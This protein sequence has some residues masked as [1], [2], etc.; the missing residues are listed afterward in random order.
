MSDLNRRQFVAGVA[1][2][3]GTGVMGTATAIAQSPGLGPLS[4]LQAEDFHPLVGQE[5]KIQPET[6]RTVTLTLTEVKALPSN[7]RPHDVRQNPFSLLFQGPQHSCF[8][9]GTYELAHRQFG[10]LPM[11]IVPIAANAGIST[12]ETIVG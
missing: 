11:L 12:Y 8:Q 4:L 1:T 6:G 7:N 10:R 5:F 2:T 9:Q 3:C